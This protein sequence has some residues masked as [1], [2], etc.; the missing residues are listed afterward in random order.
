[1]TARVPFHS[2]YTDQVSHSTPLPPHLL[3]SFPPSLLPSFPPT[4]T[5]PLH[6]PSYFLISHLVEEKK[7]KRE[8]KTNP[9]L[10]RGRCSMLCPHQLRSQRR[11]IP[12][13][14]ILFLH[15][16]IQNRRLQQHRRL[17]RCVSSHPCPSPHKHPLSTSK[18]HCC[19]QPLNISFVS[20]SPLY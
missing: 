19:H 3:P 14:A 10:P 8:K 18:I 12:T 11:P 9:P 2:G 15:E 5:L 1:M 7:R 20:S 13:S 17:I 16:H 6:P 4:L